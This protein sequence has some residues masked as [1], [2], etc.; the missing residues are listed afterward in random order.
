M[1]PQRS[2]RVDLHVLEIFDMA[3]TLTPSGSKAGNAA[4][5]AGSNPKATMRRKGNALP[6]AGVNGAGGMVETSPMLDDLTYKMG[7]PQNQA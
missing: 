5:L 6:G 7:F 4:Q 1:D 2:Q 3:M